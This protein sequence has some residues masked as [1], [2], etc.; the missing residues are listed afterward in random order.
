[1]FRHRPP[2]M[3]AVAVTLLSLAVFGQTAASPPAPARRAAPPSPAASAADLEQRGDEL[4]AEKAYLDALD[5]YAAALR[6]QPSAAIYNKSGICELMLL[7][8]GT[9]RKDFDRAIKLDRT[10]PEAYNNRGA[11]AYIQKK[12]GKAV[13]DYQQALKLRDDSPSFH[14]NLGMAYM[15]RKD[16]AHMAAEFARALQLDP[17]VFEHRSQS[18]IAAQLGSPEDQARYNYFLARVY[19]KAGNSDAALRCL[20]KA[21]ENG[22]KD[23]NEVYKDSEFAAL[24]KDPR[25]TELMA[26]KP[27]AIP[28]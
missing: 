18:G 28:Q 15:E 2:L 7:H 21:L 13:R 26:Q 20:K 16:Y 14:A 22:Y 6:K 27:P 23:M 12:Y 8:Y 4:R 3:V 24:R 5:H 1:M 19:A 9:A 17:E 10:F 11:V 25:F